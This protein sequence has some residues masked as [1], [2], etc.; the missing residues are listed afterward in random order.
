MHILNLNNHIV[1]DFS[2][3]TKLSNLK[4][5][6]VIAQEITDTGAKVPI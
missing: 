4:A 2:L 3:P 5:I 6:K 1:T